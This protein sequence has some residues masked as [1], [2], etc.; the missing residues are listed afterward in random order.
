[1]NAILV[2]VGYDDLI[3]VT[4]PY[5]RHH[6]SRVMV[7]TTPGS[8]DGEVAKK[9]DCEVFET[10][11]FYDNGATFN[12]WK[13]LELGLDALGREGWLCLMDGDIL[14]PKKIE[15]VE[16]PNGVTLTY[17]YFAMTAGQLCS[18]LR[19]MLVDP[20][21]PFLRPPSEESWQMLPLHRNVGEH[22]GYTQIFH[23]SD[24]HLGSPPW[25]EI[26]WKHCGG[27]D[28]FFQAK[29]GS[30]IDW[31]PGMPQEESCKVRPPFEVL[32][33][34]PAGENWWGRATRR[35]DGTMSIDAQE[36]AAKTAGIWSGR[37][38]RQREGLDPYQSD[39]E[40][41]KEQ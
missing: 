20:P 26:D 41:I 15:W 3:S 12:K 17:E 11:S 34:G 32:H 4:L 6:F 29:W 1:M 38:E 33:I 39:L 24:E 30:R 35:L 21:M 40:R 19:R 28:S 8:R 18:P 22:A 10:T 14:W 7:V 16:H 25:H 37:R 23:A 36:K 5:N 13:G 2:S 27:A 31:K 9:N